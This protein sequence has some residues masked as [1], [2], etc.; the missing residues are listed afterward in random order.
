MNI[1]AFSK[2][3]KANVNHSLL[4]FTSLFLLLTFLGIPAPIAA[5]PA[6]AAP[7]GC[8]L[9]SA[10]GDI[11]HV[12]YL[13][14]DNVHFLRDNPNVPS[15]LEQMPNLLN[16]IR[17]N[18]TLLTNDH[19]VL[20]S[21]T[22]NGILTD[23]TGLY[24]DRHGQAVSNSY[25]YFKTDGTTASS[26]S[27]KYWTDLVDDTGNPPADPLANMVTG[28]SGAPK[29][30]PA[31]WVPYTRAGCDFGAVAL[32]NTVLENTGIGPNGDMTKVFGAN[33]SEWLE[34]QASNAAPAGTAARNLAQT[35]FVGLAVH[36][37]A[38]G[39]MCANNSNARPDLLPDESG[40]YNNFLGLFGAKYVNPA[41]TGGNAVVDK[42][43]GDP[44]TDQF[45]QPG[46]PGFDGLFATTTL[47]YVALM[48]EAGIP[49]TF[50]YI[51]DAHDQHG[52]AGEIH[53]TR[54]P[55]EADYVQQLKDY[56]TAFGQFFDRLAADGI[57]KG[58]T[59]FVF[60][61]EEGDHFVGSPPTNP[62]CDGVNTPCTYS[63]VGEVN[64]NLA[65]LMATQQSI[66]TPFTVHSDMAPTIYIT[67]NPARTDAVT[68]DFG[69]ALGNLTAV[70]PYT[71]NSDRIA[72]A[73]A[74]PVEM[75][76]LHMVTADPQRTPTL[77]L[78]AAADYFLFAGAANCN[79]P[80]ISVP[81]TP[82]TSTF[83]WNHGG[84]QPEIATTWLG[85]VG[86]G[87]RNN[88]DDDVWADHTDTRPTMLALVGLKD[89]YVHDGRVLI[90]QLQAWAVPQ[91]LR[92]H[93]EA[94]RDLGEIY[95]QL[96]APF[97]S[98][99]MDT[100][101]ASTR[102]IRSGSAANDRSYTLIENSIAALTGKRDPLAAQIKTILDD[103]AFN[104]KPANQLQVLKLIVQAKILLEQ[105]HELNH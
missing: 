13:I 35:D 102:A 64:G 10:K 1:I 15:D 28:D 19:T 105:A 25:R 26:S 4:R 54:G 98:F 5:T 104:G 84:I 96:N 30:T 9:N 101:V 22:A 48:Q 92:A 79:A 47:S 85:I 91:T 16:F 44:V 8:Q 58:N 67:G 73:L 90:D 33:S 74:D 76:A 88:G 31:P 32:A 11:Q 24:S 62:D 34:A 43:N 77:T 71:G 87:V 78:F 2:R 103:A 40:G 55:G 57:N 45:G 14:F 86:P 17:E 36:C 23:L 37:A 50:G 61:V 81:T 68:R 89:S 53:T 94:I 12:V 52:V 46:F 27:F 70:N 80:C 18:G 29:N 63:L 20:I 41:I 39:G 93:R 72:A 66:T 82:P 59:L 95:K 65:G 83:A 60:T 56:D 97:G 6:L 21:H 49:V 69:R 38:G 75:K 7:G 99:G 100:L 3:T 51:S 42:L